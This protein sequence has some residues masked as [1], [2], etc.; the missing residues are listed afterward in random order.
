MNSVHACPQCIRNAAKDPSSKNLKEGEIT[1]VMSVNG[2]AL[3]ANH[4]PTVEDWGRR[5]GEFC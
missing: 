2:A 3:G 5:R 1:H 4:F